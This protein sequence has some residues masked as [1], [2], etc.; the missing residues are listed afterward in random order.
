MDQ[1]QHDLRIAPSLVPPYL[2]PTL[3]LAC[4][5]W[6]VI[7]LL[8]HF[9]MPPIPMN[10]GVLCQANDSMAPM[11]VFRVLIAVLGF[12][13]LGCGEELPPNTVTVLSMEPPTV[14]LDALARE[15]MVVEDPSGTL[16]VTGYGRSTPRLWKSTDAGTTWGRVEIGTEA[17][18]AVGNSDVDLAVGP[19]GTVY[20]ITL[21]FDAQAF[22]GT[23]VAVGVGREGGS[24]WT[25]TSLSQDRFDDRPW[26]AAA[27][28][29]TVHAVWSDGQGISYAAST[30]GGRSWEERPRIHTSGGASH[31]AVGPSGEIA[32]RI[33]PGAAAGQRIDEDTDY[34]AVSTDG[35][36][37]W[38][39]SVPPGTRDAQ[40]YA[41]PGDP[42]R[43]IPRWVEPVAW[44]AG[45]SL[46]YLWSE[47]SI[48]WLGQSVDQ[49]GTWSTWQIA[50]DSSLM[51][52]P[53]LAADQEGELAA[54][55]FSGR[56]ADLSANVA[57][58]TLNDG[59]DP[60]PH[61]TRVEPFQFDSFW[62]DENG[63]QNRSTAGEYIPV[64]FLRDGRLA[65][66]STV[67]NPE[68]DEWG[69]TW[70]PILRSP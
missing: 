24:E 46:Y 27:P 49:G 4:Y 23:G 50:E 58:I 5:G 14:H 9:A 28:D 51:Y 15:P 36:Q 70:R 62:R 40:S 65:T 30:D 52:F 22:E 29:G 37:S 31:L 55:W 18:G 41:F 25:W 7:S 57:L 38:E 44:D 10:S 53:Y 21:S 66:V 56:D 12:L 26:I 39:L 48:V 6:A 42:D 54:T 64:I 3:R 61:V 32:V 19:D 69:F 60:T 13:M 63:Q 20:M 67:Q 2:Q 33:A 1:E 35:G 34:I 11:P 43:G 68:K 59:A 45:G 8:K 16:F 17:D 47:G